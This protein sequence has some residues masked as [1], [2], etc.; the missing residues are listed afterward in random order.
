MKRNSIIISGLGVA[1]VAVSLFLTTT[2]SS[3]DVAKYT[4]NRESLDQEQGANGMLEWLKSTMTDVET[5]DVITES[6]LKEVMTQYRKSGSM[7]KAIT[8]DWIE[9]GPD[10]IGG[11][12]RAILVDHFNDKEIWS[13]GV[14]GGLFKS[15][16]RANNW[17]RIDNFPGGQF[18]SSIEQDAEGNIYVATGSADET[19]TGAGE[20]LFVTPDKGETWELVTGTDSES[21]I[22]RVAATQHSSTVYFTTTT[23][24]K[25]FTYGGSVDN[26]AS[27]PG[28]GAK[29]LAYSDDGE[30]LVVAANN[31]KTYVS[32]DWGQNFTGVS[33][34]DPNQ[35]PFTN[36]TRIE[37]AISSKK[38]NG[39]YSI[40][41]AL[42][43]ND[44]QGQWISLDDGETWHEHT[45]DTD[46]N[47]T[48]GVIDYRG[49]GTYNSVV[50]FDPSDPKRAIVGGID[51]HEWKQQ[52]NNPPAGS[53]N[54]ISIW[55]VNPTS[56]FYVHAD[57]HEL[58]WDDDERLYIGNDG[59]IGVST[60]KAQTFYPANRGFNITQFYHVGYDRN[61]SVIGGTQD[62]GCLYNDHSNG[63]YQEFR[64]VSGGDG[65]STEISFFN[66]DVFFTS[67]QY[68]SFFRTADGGE[69]MNAF[70]PD[71]PSYPPTGE[72]GVHPFSSAFHFVEFYDENSEDSVNFVPQANYDAGDN[73]RVPS[74]ATGDTIDYITSDPLFYDDT[75]LYD[76]T[77][78]TTEY[79]VFDKE[80][81]AMYDLGVY[82]FTYFP[83]ASGNYPPEIDDTLEVFV[84][85]GPDT[86]V[87]DSVNAYSNYF[88]TNA[89]AGDTL[90]MRKDT[91]RLGVA[92]SS[93]KVQD[94]YQSWFVFYTA[95]NGGEIWGTRDAARLSIA[96]P[97]WVRLID[98]IGNGSSGSNAPPKLDFAWSTDLNHMFVTTGNS[99][100]RVD[101][102]GSVYSTDPDFESKCDIDAGASETNIATVQNGS[103]EGIG[104]NPD[105]SDDLVAVQG[106]NG[107]VFRSSNATSA[108]PSMT[109]VGSQNGLAFYDVI[110]DRNDS[111]LLFAS[112]FNGASV[113]EDGG[114]T[115]T[116]VTPSGAEGTPSFE[117]RQ[118][119]RTWEE[120]NRRPG[121]IYLA[122]YGSGIWST[123]AVLS[124][125]APEPIAQK[126]E[127][128]EFSM[129]VYPNPSRYNS[130]LIVDMKDD[131]D[132]E[133]QFFN[134][135]GRMVKNLTVTDAHIGRNEVMFSAEDLPQGTYLIRAKSGQQRQTTKFVKM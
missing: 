134:I 125:N 61:G 112:T 49:Q 76:P 96:D 128:D 98:G 58:K 29:T 116:D 23:G 127:A 12:T 118:S 27:F 120:G 90:D 107:D 84:P 25:K 70:E 122:T 26:V 101:S 22:N 69:T 64:Q 94:P 82:S 81:G 17:S 36:F 63:T 126:D 45:P 121:E 80:S 19:W 48:N 85:N 54:K 99:I 71:L 15:E 13:G 73:V 2:M 14:S 133:I 124:V 110:V 60:D 117:I 24:L 75:L 104:L 7:S 108:T 88:G 123:D 62:N 16:N 68:N 10:N 92:W 89:G 37:Y 114:A 91:V 83:T 5:N 32:T 47:I 30:V 41:A 52:I 109:S 105:N 18:I 39:K 21:R 6:R 106:F 130:T 131:N 111:D 119:W 67:S 50:S 79:E 86:V 20:G 35:L 59:G 53:W 9:Q 4:K 115:W 31:N 42:T 129:E 87:V 1:A 72:A 77:L 100:Y 95:E 51:L 55:N 40:Y 46:P 65:F 135:S 3:D 56:E 28:T 43:S 78:T 57:N 93:V 34:N 8:V 44:N 66:P 74:L 113:S 38:S 11:R 102:L 103:F 97:K 33:G 132:L